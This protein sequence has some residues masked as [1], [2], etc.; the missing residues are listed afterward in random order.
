MADRYWVGGSGTWDSVS[1][2]N[3]SATSGGA[4]GASVPT[5]ADDVYFDSSS[6]ATNYTVTVD[7]NVVATGSVSGS[8]LTI[9]AVTSGTFAV[10]QR[11]YIS[12]RAGGMT[13]AIIS[14]FG[15]GSGGIGTYNLDIS[16]PSATSGAV[17]GG[18]AVCRSIT[19][20]APA[21]GSL[22]ITGTRPL[23]TYGDISYPATGLT[24]SFSGD[25]GLW[26]S[27]TRTITTNNIRLTAGRAVLIGTGTYNLATALTLGGVLYIQRGI[28]N[29]NNYTIT[30]DG[31]DKETTY[32]SGLLNP[33]SSVLTLVTTLRLSTGNAFQDTTVTF[34]GAF[35]ELGSGTLSNPIKNVNLVNSSSSGFYTYGAPLRVTGNFYISPKTAAS[36]GSLG[37]NANVRIPITID[38]TFECIQPDNLQY[39]FELNDLVLNGVVNLK[40]VTFRDTTVTGTS[41]PI[42][43]TNLG[44]AGG[45]SGVNFT[46]PKTVYWNLAG[47]QNWTANGWAATSG[48][49]PSLA[50]SPLPQDT[51]IFD[52]AGAAG[53][54][55]I[56]PGRIY[57][58]ALDFSGRTT[59]VTL[60]TSTNNIFYCKDVTLSSAVTV[61]GSGTWV[62][63]TFSALQVTSAGR[64]LP[65]PINISSG[66]SGVVRLV[67]AL[68]HTGGLTITQ[69]TLDLNEK[70]L[71]SG[72]DM[73][74]VS[75]GTLT[76]GISFGTNGFIYLT[77][78]GASCT[79]TNIV[80]FTA[81]DSGGGLVFVNGGGCAVYG[82]LETR[83]NDYF[84][85]PMNVR[86]APSS[87]DFTLQWQPTIVKNLTFDSGYTGRFACRASRVI[88]NLTLASGMTIQDTGDTFR[89]LF[90]QGTNQTVQTNGV[91]IKVPVVVGFYGVG[92]IP[93][94]IN[95]NVTLL[96]NMA[97]TPT[98][99]WDSN[100]SPSTVYISKGTL[101]LNGKK[102]TTGINSSNTGI[103]ITGT[104]I[105]EVNFGNNGIIE[106]LGSGSAWN[107]TTSTN[108]TITGS[109]VINTLSTSAK[110]FAGG[111]ANFQGVT[112][113]QGGAG[114]L[115]ITGANTFG[116]ITNTVQPTTITF[117]ASTTTNVR[118]FGVSGTAGNLV[119]INS[120]TA[121][122]R[123]TLNKTTGGALLRGYLSIRDSAATPAQVWFAG[124]TSTDVSNNTGW[125]FG[126]L[127]ITTETTTLSDTNA[128][129]G[130]FNRTVTES[131][132]LT[133]ASTG[134]G[135]F[136]KERNE[137]AVLSD[138]TSS[139]ASY[140]VS[141]I[142]TQT[143]TDSSIG[144]AVY[145]N[146]ANESMT[147][148]DS[149]QKTIT[150]QFS[151]D[152]ITTL[153]DIQ[154]A[155]FYFAG[156]VAELV[157][158]SE[159]Q[160]SLAVYVSARNEVITVTDRES[161]FGWF[162]VNTTQD[163][164]WTDINNTQV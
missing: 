40:N 26:A 65:V 96:D 116:N 128:A 59:A 4:G 38:G 103:N 93:T 43:G 53:T 36:P 8:V 102:L 2:T 158:L 135:I 148:T 34:T 1:T 129:I 119:T 104:T 106:I 117:P 161:Y 85:V 100:A 99:T 112:L 111:G 91:E 109:G 113:N 162:P 88:G 10:G 61:T 143:L 97:V 64:T 70:T 25:F 134:T 80:N 45:N 78:S 23:L 33:G 29:T 140:V 133:D 20:T 89:G 3:W 141:Q 21:S 14:S 5:N 139:L 46:S 154:S 79:G 122:T 19:I 71:T 110:T 13:T 11:I 16:L 120:S 15:T 44:D 57:V 121:G 108:L 86:V 137:S 164:N 77:K 60:A 153:T 9:T 39:L 118:N 17:L 98:N 37:G 72:G 74:L 144:T 92:L 132:T 7:C 27:D 58:G 42:S 73:S 32:G 87:I 24:V 67:D 149:T 22:T 82:P 30:A 94:S 125:I 101:N 47:T 114:T 41:A 160:T 155:V 76:R 6:S 52:N 126:D 145:P 163:P 31:I 51:C 131:E 107:S 83:P 157:R 90:L 127:S 28:L 49:T 68:T 142:D 146:A 152:E 56:N 156:A 55:T 130:T 124:T 105:R 69:G 159:A 150:M 66:P 136:Y 115:T 62:F 75:N 147:L 84:T 123:A 138:T 35:P 151:V 81:T 63:R 54:I 95:P 48:G 50:N 12:F 18:I